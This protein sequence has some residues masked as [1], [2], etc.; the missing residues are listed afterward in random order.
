MKVLLI[1]SEWPDEENPN[2]APFL[3]EQV[4]E[5]RKSG[6]E[7]SVFPLRGHGNVFNYLREWLNIRRIPIWKDIDLIHAHWGQSAFPALFSRKKLVITFHGS[8]LQ[9]IVDTKGNYSFFGKLLV[10]FSRWV[11]C[12]AD[13]CILVSEHLKNFLP[14]SVKNTTVIPVGVDLQ[15]FK[16][17]GKLACR[18][19]LGLDFPKR[20]VIFVS[21]PKRPE[22]QYALAKEAVDQFNKLHPNDILDLLVVYGISHDQIPYYLNAA[23]ALILSSSHEGSPMVVKE[24]LACRLPV[25]SFDVGD[26]KERIGSL[27]WCYLCCENTTACLIKGLEHIFLSPQDLDPLPDLDVIDEKKNVS[28]I[29]KI[30]GQLL[31]LKN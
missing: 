10:R 19:K 16:P 23:D 13:H 18:Q 31:R 28:K 12:R 17:M 30:Y 6:L 2:A 3:M 1:T 26:V 9:G 27:P 4:A 25:V 7:I 20:Y 15:K 22:K 14:K 5:L 21:D 24:A 11:A 8:D 29:I